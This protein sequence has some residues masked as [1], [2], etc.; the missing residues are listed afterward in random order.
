MVLVGRDSQYTVEGWGA[1]GAT[2]LNIIQMFL[3]VA[4]AELNTVT[5]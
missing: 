5:H 1:G 3:P 2:K 4:R